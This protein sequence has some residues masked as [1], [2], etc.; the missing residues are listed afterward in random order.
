MKNVKRFRLN[1]NIYENDPYGEEKWDDDDITKKL[2][3][4][5]I[6]KL[7]DNAYRCENF[8]NTIGNDVSN[9]DKLYIIMEFSDGG[10]NDR[11]RT[12]CLVRARSRNEA[13][14]IAYLTK[15]LHHEV[16]TT[17]FYTA[18]LKNEDE[19]RREINALIRKLENFQNI[20]TVDDI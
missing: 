4:S 15:N 14:A 16:V 12:I 19:Y 18:I 2:R 1:E 9:E 11:G 20:T 10:P 13:K 5:L 8:I 7:G 3:Q 6:E 17:G